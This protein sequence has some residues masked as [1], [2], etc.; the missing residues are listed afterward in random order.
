MYTALFLFVITYLLMLV[1]SKYRT[2][3][4]LTSAGLF[5]ITGLLPI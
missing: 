1:F 5:V 4:A 2:H 3:I